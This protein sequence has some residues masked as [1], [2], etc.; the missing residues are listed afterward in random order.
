MSIKDLVPQFRKDKELTR[1]TQDDSIFTFQRDMNRLF[2]EFFSD[3]GLAPA[4]PHADKAVSMFTPKVNIA[5]TDK[6]ITVTAELPG[7]DEK[8]VKVEIDDNTLVIQ[9]EKKEDHEEKDKH[10][11]R[12]EHSYGS[13]HRVIPLPATVDGTATKA[14][15][16]KGV[17]SVSLPK[18][19]DDKTK[20]RTIEVKTE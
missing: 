17:L 13:F 10:W 1:R 3:F 7:M 6:E 12:I 15:F 18:L 2:D 14:K 9:G 4:W 20:R 5:E 8:D 19:E 16:K 11:H